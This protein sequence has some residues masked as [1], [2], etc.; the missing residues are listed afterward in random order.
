[1]NI[2]IKWI[3]HFNQLQLILNTLFCQI[4]S[5]LDHLA[6][7]IYWTDADRSTIE[8]FDLDTQ[9][10]AIVYHYMGSQTPVAL[11]LVPENG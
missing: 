3:Y 11:A 1:M 4:Y 5:D 7:N 2:I 10:R 8:V 6:N 9:H